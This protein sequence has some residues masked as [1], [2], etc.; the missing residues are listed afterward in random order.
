MKIKNIITTLLSLLLLCMAITANAQISIKYRGDVDLG[1]SLGVGTFAADRINL[2]T[3]Q[4]VQIGKHFSTGLGV[5]LDYYYDGNELV[6]PLFL[7]LKGYYPI[8]SLITPFAS[9]DIGVGVGAT[10]SISRLSG[11]YCT[12][13]LGILLKKFKILLGYNI[14]KFSEDDISV[15]FKALQ[16][17]FGYVF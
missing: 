16:L 6:V 2:H 3:T 7:N 10:E 17:K 11:L 4:G 5:G 8:N 1:F 14:Q 9:L 15:S 12:P 13:A